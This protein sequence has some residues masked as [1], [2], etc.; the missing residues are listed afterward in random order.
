MSGT[1]QVRT[2]LPAPA[3]ATTLPSGDSATCSIIDDASGRWRTRYL[4]AADAFG[5]ESLFYDYW[6]SADQEY[7][8]GLFEEAGKKVF[9][10]EYIGA[11][12]YDAYF[13]TLADQTI[14]IVGYPAA[15]DHA[16][17]ELVVPE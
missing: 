7:R 13:S 3:A 10:I 14:D 5:T 12:K 15:P 11:A 16:L 1:D 4:A 6:S 9:N 2:I 8:L 17:D